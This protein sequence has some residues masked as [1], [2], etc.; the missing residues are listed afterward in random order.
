VDASNVHEAITSFDPTF[1]VP[2]EIRSDCN[3]GLN[4]V[5]SQALGKRRWRSDEQDERLLRGGQPLMNRGAARQGHLGGD[6]RK[7]PATLPPWMDSPQAKRR[8]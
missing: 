1:E 5:A 7:G 3:L 8:D 6:D 2:I 4:R